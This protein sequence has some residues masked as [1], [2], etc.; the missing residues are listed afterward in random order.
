MPFIKKAHELIKV[1][2]PYNKDIQEINDYA[3]KVFFGGID[4]NFI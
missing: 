1:L 4:E 2:T 3:R